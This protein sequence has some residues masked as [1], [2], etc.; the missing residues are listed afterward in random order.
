VPSTVTWCSSLEERGLGFGGCPVDLVGE[1][2]LAHDRSWPELER[3]RP[4]VEDRDARNVGREEVRRELDSPEGAPERPGESFRQHG[5]ARAG[6]V[7]HEDVAAAQECD[8]RELDLVVLAEDDPLD[9]LDHAVDPR[10]ESFLH[11]A[12]YPS[13]LSFRGRLVASIRVA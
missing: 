12:S 4:L 11:G 9:V 1:D 2:H 3:V 8:E 7:L 13:S 10:R 5:L 6:N